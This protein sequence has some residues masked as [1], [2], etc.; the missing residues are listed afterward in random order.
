MFQYK[1][2]IKNF[3]QLCDYLNTC[4]YNVTIKSHPNGDFSDF[5]D[6]LADKY[7]FVTHVSIGWK[8]RV[9]NLSKFCDLMICFSEAPSLL[10]WSI[11]ERIPV[12]IYDNSDVFSSCRVWYTFLYFGHNPKLV[13]VL[14]GNFNKWIDEKNST[15]K[16][17]RKI[18]KSNYNANENSHLVLNKDQ[19]NKNIINKKFQL[20]DA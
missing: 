14:D 9:H 20:I 2:Y 8:E 6:L 5:Y 3:I 7:E 19:I 4:K 11:S 12:I 15:S 17:I 1:V 10:V 13:S 16:E 18:N